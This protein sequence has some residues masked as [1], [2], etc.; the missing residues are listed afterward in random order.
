MFVPFLHLMF[1]PRD[2]EFAAH[3]DPISHVRAARVPERAINRAI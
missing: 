1:P 3:G 2:V